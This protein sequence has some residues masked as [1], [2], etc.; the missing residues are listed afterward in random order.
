MR[1]FRLNLWVFAPEK[2]ISNIDVNC[3]TVGL[4]A[5]SKKLSDSGS[6]GFTGGRGSGISTII[7]G[8][9]FGVGLGGGVG[10]GG[11]GVGSCYVE[12]GRP[13]RRVDVYPLQVRIVIQKIVYVSELAAP[14][15][16]AVKDLK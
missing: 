1:S 5:A 8:F 11:G 13:V 14:G 4:R 10:V 9:G 6:S 7:G 15:A 3:S 12:Q 2:G 16:V